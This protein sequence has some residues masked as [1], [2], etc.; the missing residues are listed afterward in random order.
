[1]Q[2]LQEQISAHVVER[3]L[4]MNK[5]LPIPFGGLARTASDVKKGRAELL[6]PNSGYA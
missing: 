1:M 4:Q 2:R 6:I 3:T 5:R